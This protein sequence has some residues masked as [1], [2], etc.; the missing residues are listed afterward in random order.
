M[1]KDSFDNRTNDSTSER[2]QTQLA[3]TPVD[4]SQL[5]LNQVAYIRRAVI[6]EQPVWAI[7]NAAGDQ[8]GAAQTREQAVGA[9][10]QHDLTPLYVN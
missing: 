1:I 3:S 10:L 2:R 4:L 6:D 8:V 7:H 5:G 9:I